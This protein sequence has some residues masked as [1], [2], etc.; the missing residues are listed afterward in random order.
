M[1]GDLPEETAIRRSDLSVV[2]NE[3]P[4]FKDLDYPFLREIAADSQWLSLPGP[5]ATLFAAGDPADALYVV[6]SGCPG[7]VLARR[8]PQPGLRRPR[9]GRR[10][11]RGNGVDFRPSPQ[12]PRRRAARHGAGAALQRIVQQAVSPTPG[13]HAAHRPSHRLTRLESSQ[14]RVRV[15]SH[16]AR[17]FT[18]L[19]QSVEVDAGGFAAELVKALSAFGRTELVW[20]VRAGTHTS[21][22]FHRIESAN[23]YVVYV[24]E[25]NSGRWSN[26]CVRQ[27]DALLLL[28]RPESEAG[29]WP[30]LVRAPDT[31]MAPQRAEL[32]LIHDGALNRGAAARWLAD[33]PA[34]TPHHHVTGKED[35]P[36]VARML[37]GRGVGLVLSGG[38]EARFRAHRYR[39]SASRGR[40]SHRS[41]RRH[42][43]GRDPRRRVS[44][45]VGLST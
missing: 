28:A 18:L 3:L 34:G 4:L 14:S 38:G 45:C 43:H 40:Y 12:C 29:A 25:A 32:V 10:Y 9:R 8:A 37:T 39:E 21:H 26:L 36:R 2:F 20:N 17:T 6:L 41:R 11:R 42:Q 24:A 7:R 13:G 31:A 44:R 22:W 33:L 15:H 27:A 5:G 16:A 1:E 19:P 30:N 23:E 35:V